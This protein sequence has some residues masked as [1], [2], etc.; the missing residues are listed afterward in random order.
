MENVRGG[1]AGVLLLVSMPM[2][3]DLPRLTSLAGFHHVG[4]GDVV[5]ARP[6]DRWGPIW[7]CGRTGSPASVR[8]PTP[9]LPDRS[10]RTLIGDSHRGLLFLVAPSGARQ[11]SARTS[12]P[13]EER[14][15]CVFR[16][17]G[18]R[19]AGERPVA[20]VSRQSFQN[21]TPAG[22][23]PSVCPALADRDAMQEPPVALV[24]A[25]GGVHQAAV[26][27]HHQHVR[28]PAVAVHEPIPPPGA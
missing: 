26:V 18:S 19:G 1:N 8:M 11:S 17:S 9:T 4:G 14:R 3:I 16:R 7:T 15:V 13:L 27:P 21:R 23:A 20:Q 2:R 10:A 24:A 12:R 6:L 22:A 28:L 5:K 25:S